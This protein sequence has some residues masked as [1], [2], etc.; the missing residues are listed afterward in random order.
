LKILS[1]FLFTILSY[2]LNAQ[3]AELESVGL[4]STG[5]ANID[6]VIELAIRNNEFAGAVILVA[7]HGKIAYHKAFGF[8]DM[9]R[10]METNAIFRLASMTKTISAV[11]VM[12][13]V[14]QGRIRLADPVSKYIPEFKNPKVLVLN[15]DNSDMTYNLVTAKREILIHDLLAMT[16]GH[17]S[18]VVSV[19]GGEVRAI[20]AKM[21]AEA[22]L[23]D[24]NASYDMTLEKHA[25]IISQMPLTGHPGEIYEYG[26]GPD[27]AAY[28]VEIITGMSFAEYLKENIFKPLQM[29]DTGYYPSGAKLKR[30]TGLFAT[31]SLEKVS[32][33]PIQFGEGYI[34]ANDP[35][36]PYK[37]FF[38]GATGLT[39]TAYDY[40]KFA[41][42]LL[43]KGQ[44]DGVRILGRNSVEIMTTNQIGDLADI[45]GNKWGYGLSIQINATPLIDGAFYGGIG[46]YGWSGLWGTRFVVNP[47]ESMVLVIMT[48]TFELD[49]VI[50]SVTK[51]T[52]I[53]SGAIME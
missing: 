34:S 28:V 31:G 23:N 13:L 41:Q 11:A 35:Y 24:G 45:F 6:T 38:G 52:A 27:V 53:T 2:S 30:L 46:A 19:L 16:S 15:S 14:E 20:Q 47:R 3:T 7:R 4:S 25:R 22:R 36:G 29:N 37:S 33:Q 50:D 40:F 48:P 49:D 43:N 18:P 32:D 39:S 5:L 42:M 9:D 26:V 44:L 12:Q 17:T 8:A 21:M 1:L 51:I 10:P